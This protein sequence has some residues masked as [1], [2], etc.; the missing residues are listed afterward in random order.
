M[1]IWLEQNEKCVK[2]GGKKIKSDST[3]LQ[4]HCTVTN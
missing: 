3:K 1:G 2:S 4:I